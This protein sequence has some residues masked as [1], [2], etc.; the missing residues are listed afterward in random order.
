MKHEYIFRV[1]ADFSLWFRDLKK[2]KHHIINTRGIEGMPVASLILDWIKKWSM[3]VSL[4]GRIYSWRKPAMCWVLNSFSILQFAAHYDDSNHISSKILWPPYSTHWNLC[5]SSLITYYWILFKL[6]TVTSWTLWHI[7]LL[8][9][10]S[11]F[12]CNWHL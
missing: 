10:N 12:T 5:V 4:W 8:H 11:I 3:I 6:P 9:I 7:T 1:F 2:L